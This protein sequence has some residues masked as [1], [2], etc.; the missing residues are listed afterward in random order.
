MGGGSVEAAGV[1]AGAGAAGADASA[2]TNTHTNK[3][4][5][6]GWSGAVQDRSSTK[7][8]AAARRFGERAASDCE[9]KKGLTKQSCAAGE[10]R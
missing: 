7:K 8:P 2:N 9:P 5:W 4:R 6:G 10:L 1:G 3:R